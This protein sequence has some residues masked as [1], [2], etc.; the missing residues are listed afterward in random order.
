MV[1]VRSQKSRAGAWNSLDNVYGQ[2]VTPEYLSAI[3]EHKMEQEK[4]TMK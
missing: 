2:R 3:A 4:E 1:N